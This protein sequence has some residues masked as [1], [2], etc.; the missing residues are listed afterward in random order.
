MIVFNKLQFFNKERFLLIA[1]QDK[2]D[3]KSI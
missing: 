3:I 2:I 1:L